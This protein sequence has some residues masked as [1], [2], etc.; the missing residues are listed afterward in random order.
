MVT[1]KELIERLQYLYKQFNKIPTRDLYE[2]FYNSKFPRK[3]GTFRIILKQ[4]GFEVRIIKHNYTKQEIF[5]LYKEYFKKNGII[6]AKYLPKSLPCY[7]LVLKYWG[8]YEIFLKELGY[9]PLNRMFYSKFSKEEM[10]KYLRKKYDE[11]IFTKFSDLS[12][13]SDLPHFDTLLKILNVNSWKE[14][15]KLIDRP[16]YFKGFI[17]KKNKY[18]YTDEELILLY[19]NLSDKLNKNKAGATTRDIKKYLNINPSLYN[20]RFVSLSNLKEFLGYD[21]RKPVIKYNLKKEIM[22]L[23]H[24]KKNNNI[25]NLKIKDIKLYSQEGHA[26]FAYLKNH[27]C[28]KSIREL[29]DF[30]NDI[31]KSNL[32]NKN[33]QQL[34]FQIFNQ[35]GT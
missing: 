17:S 25:K 15:V 11:G 23:Y 18:Y 13:K 33:I 29:N 14:I 21:Y 35:S 16:L 22:A 28:I 1:K 26:S 6:E 8:K 7:D 24:Y 5:N 19:K 10:I 2:T 9:K 20:I 27:L 12:F 31:E 30:L 3:Y 4:A 34:S 32:K